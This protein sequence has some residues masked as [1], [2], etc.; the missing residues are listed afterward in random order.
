MLTRSP[1]VGADAERPLILGLVW[2]PAPEA[3][4]GDEPAAEP[5]PPVQEETA[6][7]EL[8]VE[9]VVVEEVEGQ[10]GGAD[11]TEQAIAGAVAA[12]EARGEADDAP[13]PEAVMQGLAADANLSEETREAAKQALGVMETKPAAAPKNG[14]LT[15]LEKLRRIP[16]G[17][18]SNETLSQWL[19]AIG[20]QRYVGHLRRH[21][22]DGAALLRF[23]ELPKTEWPWKVLERLGV[24]PMAH[25]GTIVTELAEVNGWGGKVVTNARGVPVTSADVAR[26]PEEPAMSPREEKEL[27]RLRARV[28]KEA[29]AAAK[30]SRAE[31]ASAAKLRQAKVALTDFE[32]T[33]TTSAASNGEN[34]R[35]G[36]AQKVSS[37]VAARRLR[38]PAQ[39]RR[40]P[41]PQ[42]PKPQPRAQGKGAWLR[43]LDGMPAT[44]QPNYAR[45]L[46]PKPSK[47]SK[48]QAEPGFGKLSEA[49]ECT[50]APT[51]NSASRAKAAK[52]T[53]LAQRH[54]KPSV[55]S[56]RKSIAAD[57]AAPSDVSECTFAPRLNARTP[58]KGKN[59]DSSF[60]ERLNQ[61][62]AKR[63][64]RRERNSRR[65]HYKSTDEMQREWRSPSSDENGRR[66][67]GEHE[68]SASTGRS[69]DQHVSR[70]QSPR[71]VVDEESYGPRDMSPP[72]WSPE[73]VVSSPTGS[74]ERRRKFVDRY[75]EEGYYDDDGD[76]GSRGPSPTHRVS[77]W[78]KG[79]SPESG[80]RLVKRTPEASASDTRS[81]TRSDISGF[82]SVPSSIASEEEDSGF[83][84]QRQ[85]VESEAEA[86]AAQQRT[87]EQAPPK[88]P[89]KATQKKA[90]KEA[91][92]QAK[93]E[94]RRERKKK[95]L[96]KYMSSDEL[97]AL[98]QH[99]LVQRQAELLD[100][101]EGDPDNV[102]LLQELQGL[103]V[104]MLQ[105]RPAPQPAEG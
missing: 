72:K 43:K 74:A 79:R 31:E 18:W 44:A 83:L 55:V 71:P 66:S 97:L 64:F 11:K 62:L 1:F 100:A 57:H 85:D 3:D 16:I 30:A 80:L 41:Q 14:A 77:D 33:T 45:A 5:L 27:R 8:D 29:A 75:D 22:V 105:Q 26:G 59:S 56:R 9:L 48:T 20:L 40:Q 2:I 6:A 69:I 50:F 103:H 17:D 101:L 102:K 46:S 99:K 78:Q 65:S 95:R 98:R 84:T 4:E 12:W 19:R 60:H 61:D 39:K 67:A 54:D 86:S 94:R 63:E 24:R 73:K 93:E 51:M 58:L 15:A 32:Q 35:R 36:F 52:A 81:D 23:A 104:R 88:A 68:S 47:A 49:A 34:G 89:G 42:Q 25:R 87:P 13:Q 70:L 82:S 21:S 90:K 92:K 37:V 76:D 38:S 91:K 10:E 53:P 96:L 7:E 28:E